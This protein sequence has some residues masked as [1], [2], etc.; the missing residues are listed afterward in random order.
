MSVASIFKTSRQVLAV[1]LLHFNWMGI[2]L[3]KWW[4][5][6]T[7]NRIQVC[8][9]ELTVSNHKTFFSSKLDWNLRN[10]LI[11]C[12]IWSIAFYSAGY[13]ILQKVYQKYQESSKCGAGKGWISIG[14]IVWKMGFYVR[15]AKKERD[16]LNTTRRRKFKLIGYILRRNFLMKHTVLGKIESTRRLG[17]R[18][19]QLLCDLKDEEC[20]GSWK[21]KH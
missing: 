16:I 1:K 12:H 15:R 7:L 11:K 9:G 3:S 10:K 18:R 6:Y 17:R 5:M 2:V 19:K 14:P 4:N 20:T 21:T 13:W 8:N